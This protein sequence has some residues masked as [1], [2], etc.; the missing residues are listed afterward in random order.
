MKKIL[1]TFAATLALAGPSLAQDYSMVPANV[2][3]QIKSRCVG[4]N[5]NSYLMQSNCIIA[6]MA[7]YR[8]MQRALSEAPQAPARARVLSSPDHAPQ[9]PTAIYYPNCSAARAAGA[10]PIRIGEPGYARK[11]DRDGDVIACE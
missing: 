9:P 4:Q 5:P 3:A 8:D 6:E 2:K 10:A 7:G 1:I 11:L